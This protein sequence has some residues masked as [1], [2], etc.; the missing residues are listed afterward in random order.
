MF[1][2]VKDLEDKAKDDDDAAYK[3]GAEY[4]NG[5]KIKTGRD[6]E[7][8]FGFYLGAANKGNARAEFRIGMAYFH[9]DITNKD[10]AKA[11]QFLEKAAAKNNASAQYMVGLIHFNKGEKSK[12]LP[13]FQDALSRGMSNS[14]HWIKQ[15]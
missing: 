3:A 6:N 9:G 12:A 7:K 14:A 15:I 4:E 8:A 11:L 10:P 1:L 5:R 2:D 13:F